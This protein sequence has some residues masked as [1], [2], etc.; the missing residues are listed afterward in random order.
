MNEDDRQT[1]GSSFDTLHAKV[2][3]NSIPELKMKALDEAHRLYGPDAQLQIVNVGAIY[4]SNHIANHD[5]R[6]QWYTQV[7]VRCLNVDETYGMQAPDGPPD[8]SP[9]E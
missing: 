8:D 6:G 1:A 9:Q 4:A 7:T 2:H 5:G 3:G